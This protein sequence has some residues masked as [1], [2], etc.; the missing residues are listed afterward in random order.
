MP[1]FDDIS[2]SPAEIKL[3]PVLEKGR[4]PYW[5]YFSGFDYDLYIVNGISFCI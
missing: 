1:N 3:L 2:Q 5:N 4:S